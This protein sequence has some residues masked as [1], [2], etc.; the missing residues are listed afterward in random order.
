MR[1]SKNVSRSSLVSAG[2]GAAA[3]VSAGFVRGGTI[4]G[5]TGSGLWDFCA[6]WTPPHPVASA[7][8]RMM[9]ARLTILAKL[10]VQNISSP[11]VLAYRSYDVIFGSAID[12][13]VQRV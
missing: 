6:A 3:D 1:P 12:E 9:G 4:I 8:A 13:L 11:S 10:L 5:A 2:R 7:S